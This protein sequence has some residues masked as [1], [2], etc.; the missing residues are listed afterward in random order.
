MQRRA[1]LASTLSLPLV[2]AGSTSPLLAL[3]GPGDPASELAELQRRLGTF[4]VRE[5][6]ATLMEDLGV[7][8]RIHAQIDELLARR[9]TDRGFRSIQEL[10]DDDVLQ[11]ELMEA[12]A[13]FT[14]SLRGKLWLL[15]RTRRAP[16]TPE[17]RAA[18]YDHVFL[19]LGLDV[20]RFRG[21]VERL[22]KDHVAIVYGPI[23]SWT[24]LGGLLLREPYTWLVQLA[25]QSRAREVHLVDSNPY[26]QL[27]EVL[28]DPSIREVIFIGHGTWST[29]AMQGYRTEP[30]ALAEQLFERARSDPKGFLRDAARGI[31][32]VVRAPHVRFSVQE[33]HLARLVE[34]ARPTPDQRA[35]VYK[36]LIVRH[37]CGHGRY[38]NDA[39]LLWTQLPEALASKVATG[40]GGVSAASPA[41]HGQWEEELEAWLADKDLEITERAAF[42]E[43]FVASPDRTRGYEGDSWFPDF[44]ET[45]IPE[46]RA[47]HPAWARKQEQPPD[48]ADAE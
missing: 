23:Q 26:G 39:W 15:R 20:E 6:V 45:P 9:E 25:R 5:L 40:W 32:R 21:A 33:R 34:Q 36:D 46:H 14:S 3:A 43:S 37:T 11:T 29:F 27:V 16:E 47:P 35:A 1:F 17:A 13:W 4:D 44:F 8:R 12:T 24:E 38:G 41:E 42:G 48:I 30:D 2:V 31:H 28:M 10:L 19:T 7:P 18:L 22:E